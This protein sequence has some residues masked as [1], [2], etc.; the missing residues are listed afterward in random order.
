ME[1]KQG[2]LMPFF[3]LLVISLITSASIAPLTAQTK[4]QMEQRQL[5]RGVKALS[6]F[7]DE[8]MVPALKGVAETDPAPEFHG[9]SI[10]KRAAEAIAQ[11]QKRAQAHN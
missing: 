6:G 11:I 1:G 8:D 7:G 9:H 4:E 10:R 2:T 5:P 3:R